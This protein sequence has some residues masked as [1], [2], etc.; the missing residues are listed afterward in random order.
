MARTRKENPLHRVVT[1]RSVVDGYTNDRKDHGF[2]WKTG[3]ESIELANIMRALRDRKSPLDGGPVF[4][5]VDVKTPEFQGISLAQ[6][7]AMLGDK[8]PRFT[9]FDKGLYWSAEDDAR[10]EKHLEARA[11]NSAAAQAAGIAE[12]HRKKQQ[13]ELAEQ[14]G[15][16]IAMAVAAAKAA[17]QPAP[18]PKPK[19]KK[20]EAPDAN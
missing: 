14:M 2:S 17:E 9:E 16:M 5:I 11:E 4:K 3:A 10:L 8:A 1:L 13:A 6:R 15:P 19:T 18:A 12:A 7:L 20:S